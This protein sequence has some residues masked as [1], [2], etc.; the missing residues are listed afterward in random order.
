MND[1]LAP[2]PMSTPHKTL[3]QS[4]QEWVKVFRFVLLIAAIDLIGWMI[5]PGMFTTVARTTWDYLAEAIV[6]LIPVA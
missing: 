3:P 5:A 4:P 1:Q 6:I 2:A